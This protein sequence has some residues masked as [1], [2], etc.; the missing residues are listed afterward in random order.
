MNGLRN[1]CPSQSPQRLRVAINALCELEPRL[2]AHVYLLSLARELSGLPDV[3]VSLIV[4]NGQR[5]LLPDV[6]R[7]N[8]IEVPVRHNRSYWQIL[9]QVQ[10]ARTLRR[11]GIEIFHLPNTQP[12]LFRGA[13]K[14]VITIHDLVDLRV[15]K[16]GAVRTAYRFLTNLVAAHLADSI[17]TVSENSKRDIVS[18]LH[19]SAQKVHVIYQGADDIF[20]KMDHSGCYDY[21][22]TKYGIDGG[23]ILAPG[24][25]APNKNVE[26][27]LCSYAQALAMGLRCPLVLTGKGSEVEMRKVRKAIKRLGIESHVHLLGS[28]ERPDLP[29]LYNACAF[30][31]YL[32]LYEGF[33]LPIVEAMSCGAP[34]LASNSSSIPEIAGDAALFVDPY[35]ID[36]LTD[37]LMRLAQDGAL[38]GTLRE[39]G[40]EQAKKYDWRLTARQT[41]EVYRSVV[42][43]C[44]DTRSV[45]HSAEFN[46]TA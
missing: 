4:G 27:L 1:G 13:I 34:I 31:A 3:V 38:R 44:S 20:R 43:K 28:I 9:S 35:S 30:V 41:I 12:L 29:I 33:G 7:G 45:L 11:K 40:T 32:S 15:R 23:F 14:T 39:K 17:I 8:A 19:V 21:V 2:G 5:G 26:R 36:A 37:G 42:S 16:Y 6:L 22:K 10:I 25:M 24:G 18:L 46:E